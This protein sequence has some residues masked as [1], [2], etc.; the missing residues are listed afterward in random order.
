MAEVVRYSNSLI[1]ALEESLRSAFHQPSLVLNRRRSKFEGG[2]HVSLTAGDKNARHDDGIEQAVMNIVSP[3]GEPTDFYFGFVAAFRFVTEAILGHA[4]LSVFHDI[5]G[6]AVPLCR[7]E[8]DYDAA[9]DSE[10]DHAQPHWHFVQSPERIAGIVRTLVGTSRDF[11]PE[12]KSGVFDGL[13]DCGKI[14]FAM[15][16]LD[17]RGLPKQVFASEQFVKWFD[18]MTRYVGGQ[19]AYLTSR[20]PSPVREFVPSTAAGEETEPSVYGE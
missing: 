7:A 19:I 2:F 15:I 1:S 16:S 8:W 17:Q 10:S 4:S 5:C 20:L 18:S 14:H 9:S 13:A 12:N 6:E 11:S 3:S